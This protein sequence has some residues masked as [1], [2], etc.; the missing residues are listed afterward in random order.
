MTVEPIGLP[1]GPH[2]HACKALTMI[3][4]LVVASLLV[5]SV[6]GCSGSTASACGPQ[7]REA[8]D[9]SSLVHVL[10]GAPTPHYESSPP[11]S[12]AH[13]PTPPI[14]GV[15]T[16]P[17]APQ[18]QVGILEQG[19]VLM[20]YRGLD[21]TDVGALRK[22]ASPTVVVA[23]ARSLPG[24]ATVVAT[25]WVTK[26]SCNRLDVPTLEKFVTSRNGK[27]PGRP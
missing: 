10:P 21:P 8:L 9:P 25:A 13:Q 27:G 7:I 12:G 23:P 26:Q 19:R 16:T 11:T 17:I 6:V 20:Q 15:Q 5:S 4:S 22:L 18:V 2:T 1:D 14:T 3:R 24:S